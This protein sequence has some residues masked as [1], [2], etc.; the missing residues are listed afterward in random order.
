MQSEMA[1]YFMLDKIRMSYYDIKDLTA[2]GL[3]DIFSVLRRL[4]WFATP[5]IVGSCGKKADNQKLIQISNF[6]NN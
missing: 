6:Y 3:R 2:L 4:A 5:A 1:I